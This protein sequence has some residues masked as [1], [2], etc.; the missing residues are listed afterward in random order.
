[1]WIIT[2]VLD[3]K[4]ILFS[5]NERLKEL[6]FQANNELNAKLSYHQT[7]IASRIAILKYDASRVYCPP[8]K[9]VENVFRMFCLLVCIFFYLV[10]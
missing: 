2:A 5:T 4:G 8:Q 10:C 6:N 3:S 7:A 1:M 9:H